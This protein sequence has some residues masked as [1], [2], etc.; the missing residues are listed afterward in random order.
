MARAARRPLRIAGPIPP[1]VE[2]FGRYMEHRG[3]FSVGIITAGLAI[4]FDLREI[5]AADIGFRGE[6][7]LRE[8]ALL[9]PDLDRAFAV[10]QPNGF[11]RCQVVASGGLFPDPTFVRAAFGNGGP[12][13]RVFELLLESF[14]VIAAYSYCILSFAQYHYETHR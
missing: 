6:S 9:P 3:Q 13:L 11:V 4:L 12:I 7:T 5:A 10:E 14:P 2:F 1:G 8:T